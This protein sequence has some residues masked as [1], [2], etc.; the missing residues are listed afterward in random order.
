[1]DGM[2]L[3]LS[4]ICLNSALCPSPH[5]PAGVNLVQSVHRDLK[6]TSKV[7]EDELAKL[8][9][10]IKGQIL[11]ITTLED[12]PLS[13]VERSNETEKLMYGEFVG[14][15]WAF[16]FFEYLMTKFNFTYRIVRPDSNIVGGTNDSDGSL[17][18]MIRQNVRILKFSIG[19]L[20][21]ALH[22]IA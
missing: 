13:Y 6:S 8:A 16:E 20:N 21:D 1:M 11:N 18:M 2:A 7:I 10:E 14:R 19:L 17:M 15:G 12:F 5:P 9:A 4:A 22:L 3:M